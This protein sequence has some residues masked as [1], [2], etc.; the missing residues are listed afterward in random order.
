MRFWL[1][2][3]CLALVLYGCGS[4]VI[5]FGGSD[6]GDDDDDEERTVTVA[7]NIDTVNPPNAVRDLVLFAYTGLTNPSSEP[8]FEPA[9]FT[10]FKFGESVIVAEDDTFEMSGVG[11]GN[12]TIVVLLDDPDPDG[13]V[14]CTPTPGEATEWTCDDC[15]VLLD[16][17][18]LSDVSGGRRVT[19]EDMDVNFGTTPCPNGKPIIA[20]CGCSTAHD[21]VISRD[22]PDDGGSSNNDGN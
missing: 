17:G 22:E 15:T 18:D 9:P 8:P 6:C 1:L 11:R 12:I 19:I 10:E 7:G 13:S 16:G 20:N 4:G 2:A 14:D 21:I 5:C 3:P